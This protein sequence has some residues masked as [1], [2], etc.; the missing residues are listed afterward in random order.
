MNKHPM[1]IA[2]LESTSEMGGGEHVLLALVES[3]PRSEVQ[4]Y[5]VCPNEGELSARAAHV[6]VPTIIIPMP[7]FPSLSVLWRNQ[8]IV[9]PLAVIYDF[10]LTVLAAIRTARRLK[11]EQVELIHTNTLFAHLYGGLAARLLG[12]PCVWHVHDV[13]DARRFGG[14]AGWLWRQL[15]NVLATHIV[16]SSKAAVEIFANPDKSSTIYMGI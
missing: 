15:S 6:D 14:L 10:A 11:R 13:L 3:L 7:T 12:V 2:F 9:N 1:R 5:L 16:G 8:K 4:P